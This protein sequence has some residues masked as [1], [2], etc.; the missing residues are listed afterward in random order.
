MWFSVLLG[1]I[2]GSKITG[3]HMKS[4][5]LLYKLF[6]NCFLKWLYNFAFLLAVYKCCIC[7]QSSPILGISLLNFS[8]SRCGF[9]V[10]LPCFR[11]FLG[12]FRA[13][14]AAYGGS[15]ARGPIR[16]EAAGLH[17]SSLQHEILNPL[18]KAKDRTHI[19]MDTSQV[20]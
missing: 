2:P 6:P 17:H 12:L 8:H 16:A 4:I 14:S 10:C 3:Y 7:S 1:K 5:F 13:T 11:S 20:G 9:F 15:Q 18:S 19:L